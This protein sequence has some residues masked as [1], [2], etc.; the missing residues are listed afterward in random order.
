MWNINSL[1]HFPK[2]KIKNLFTLTKDFSKTQSALPYVAMCSVPATKK[3]LKSATKKLL[4]RAGAK[5][6]GIKLEKI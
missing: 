1:K 2:K 5:L 6:Q 3:S 4:M